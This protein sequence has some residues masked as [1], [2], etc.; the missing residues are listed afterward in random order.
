MITELKVS[1]VGYPHLHL[2]LHDH[3]HC[4]AN[5]TSA[6]KNPKASPADQHADDHKAKQFIPNRSKVNKQLLCKTSSLHFP[7]LS[8]IVHDEQKEKK[9]Q[10]CLVIL[11]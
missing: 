2:K 7:S 4:K 8:S 5:E 11:N 9:R 1:A 6:G 10:R 3:Q